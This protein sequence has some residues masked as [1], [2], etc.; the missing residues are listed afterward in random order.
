MEPTFGAIKK[1]N[2]KK[3]YAYKTSRKLT[4]ENEFFSLILL[5]DI[6]LYFDLPV[7]F[8]SLRLA[9]PFAL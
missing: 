6:Y 1:N 5:P 8:S 9:F 4:A 7:S 2:N 3:Q